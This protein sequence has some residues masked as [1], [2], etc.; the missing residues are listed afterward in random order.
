MYGAVFTTQFALVL[1]NQ[2][3][4]KC[5]FRLQSNQSCHLTVN[6]KIQSLR[7]APYTEHVATAVVSPEYINSWCFPE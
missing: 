2:C 7:R 1:F 3:S 4:M 6:N 5:N